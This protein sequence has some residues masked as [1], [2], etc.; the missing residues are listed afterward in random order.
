MF[1]S[2][3]CS[4]FLLLLSTSIRSSAIVGLGSTTSIS[5]FVV[6][7]NTWAPRSRRWAMKPTDVTKTTEAKR[8]VMMTV[9]ELARERRDPHCVL[10][11]PDPIAASASKTPSMGQGSEMRVH[12]LEIKKEKE[13]LAH[14]LNRD[15]SGEQGATTAFNPNKQ[16]GR[17]GSG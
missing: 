8:A 5:S 15:L 6:S 16:C 12:R 9:V 14:K 2:C 11:A 3:S 17:H 4:L 13:E 1:S 10:G 7:R